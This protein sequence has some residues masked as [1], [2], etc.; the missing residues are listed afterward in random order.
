[1][2]DLTNYVNNYHNR[3]AILDGVSSKYGAVFLFTNLKMISFWSQHVVFKKIIK[4]FAWWK[5]YLLTWLYT[6]NGM[7]NIKV[8]VLQ[9]ETSQTAAASTL[10]PRNSSEKYHSCSLRVRNNKTSTEHVSTILFNTTYERRYTKT[11]YN[12]P[13]FFFTVVSKKESFSF[14]GL[15]EG[16]TVPYISKA[17]ALRDQLQSWFTWHKYLL[18]KYKHGSVEFWGTHL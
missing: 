17:S 13:F 15:A 8:K 6:Y 12:F 2:W 11:H 4:G 16:F 18:T 5:L 1:L 14:T 7:A 10:T 9:V 3:F